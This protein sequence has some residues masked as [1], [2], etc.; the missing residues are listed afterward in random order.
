MGGGGAKAL[1]AWEEEVWGQCC[2]ALGNVV[3][4]E[5]Q[6]D[7]WLCLPDTDTCYSVGG[8]YH[9]LTHMLPRALSNHY[10]FIWNKFVP[11][12]VSFFAWR[13]LSD[14]LPTKNNLFLRNVGVCPLIH[15]SVH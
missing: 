5:S 9:F 6:L 15:Y 8:V 7:S 14:R 10:D 2:P 3:L 4:H 12:K 1:F 13:L 11:L